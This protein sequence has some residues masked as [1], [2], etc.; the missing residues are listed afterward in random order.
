[1][2]PLDATRQSAGKP[3]RLPTIE[4]VVPSLL[5]LPP[6]CRFADRCS[7]RAQKPPG[8]ERCTESEPELFAMADGRSSRCYFSEPAA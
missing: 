3:R 6:G 8:Y 5:D 4:G 2:P 1:V 7:L